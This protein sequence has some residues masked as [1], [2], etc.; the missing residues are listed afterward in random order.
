MYRV[1][2]YEAYPL[3]AQ[4]DIAFGL[5]HVTI[6]MIHEVLPYVAELDIGSSSQAYQPSLAFL[7]G[8]GICSNF[9]NDNNV[10]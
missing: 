9:W 10:H 1:R 7:K 8:G 5:S 4:V 2:L 3:A 6:Y